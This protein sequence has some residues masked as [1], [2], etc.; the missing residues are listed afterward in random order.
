MLNQFLGLSVPDDLVI[1]YPFN[2]Q[3]ALELSGGIVR[4]WP[5]DGQLPVA[6][7]TM[8]YTILHKICIANWIPSTHASTISAALGHFIYLVGTFMAKCW[9]VCLFPFALSCG[10]VWDQHSHLFS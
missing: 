6:S 2:K 4:S 9:R 10:L 5:N 8:K 7:L 3:L 1:Q